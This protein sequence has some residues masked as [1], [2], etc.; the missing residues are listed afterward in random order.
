MNYGTGVPEDL[1]L[2]NVL[3]N[4]LTQLHGDPSAPA[5]GGMVAPGGALP[6]M[7]DGLGGMAGLLGMQA[8]LGGAGM[9]AGLA[10]GMAPGMAGLQM[11]MPPMQAAPEKAAA[12]KQGGG[13]DDDSDPQS[14]DG[15]ASSGEQKSRKK[16]EIGGN[17]DDLTAAEK[18]HLALQEK[19]RRAQR[20]F[21]E[22]QKAKIQ[23]L[24]QQIEELTHKV[25]SLQTENAALHSRTSILEKVLDMRNEQI[26]VMQESKEITQQVDEQ[27]EG[28]PLT[29]TAVS[30]QSISLTT[31]MLKALSPE[32]IY[33]I[34]QTYIKELSSRLVELNQ[35]GCASDDITAQVEKLTKEVSFL[36]MRLSVVRPIETRKFI[37]VS[38]QYLHNEEEA[39]DMWKSVVNSIN[40]N[41]KQ[42]LD[43]VRWKQL[44]MQ[45]VEPIVDERKKLNVQ[46]QAHLPQESF[47]TRNAI[48]YIKTHEAVAKLRENLR[49]E[50][51]VTI[52]FCA[53]VFKGVLN[54]FQMAS[55]LVQAYP[56][57][58]DALAVASAVIADMND[59]GQALPSALA[60]MQSNQGLPGLSMAAP[61]LCPASDHNPNAPSTAAA[62]AAAAAAAGVQQGALIGLGTVGQNQTLPLLQ[63]LHGVAAAPNMAAAAV[64]SLLAG[65][66]QH[67][68]A[69]RRA[70]PSGRRVAAADSKEGAKSVDDVLAAANALLDNLT[71]G[72]TPPSLLQA[73]IDE[74]EGLGY[75]C[76]E[77]GCVLVLP[78]DSDASAGPPPVSRLLQGPNWSIGMLAEPDSDDE[79]GGSPYTAQVSGPCWSVPLKPG[80]LCDFVGMLSQL[81]LMVANLAA[82]GQWHGATADRPASRVKWETSHIVMK[83]AHAPGEPGFSIEMTFRTDRRS[84]STEWPADV[85]AAA[86]A[87]VDAETGGLPGSRLRNTATVSA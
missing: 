50:H 5:S 25:G 15:S 69:P 39:I 38:R 66:L 47:H 23:D 6:M 72:Q 12:S 11:A 46:I 14:S 44:F 53:A 77:S 28:P 3:D 81:R 7:P 33:K 61:L 32:Q 84:V 78:D 62:A 64:D 79:D 45:K 18:R 63:T 31:D 42:K 55:L 8:G 40:L 76:D 4:Y 43:I 34:Y 67:C 56:A 75:V 70:G 13:G 22:R 57:V 83:A 87:A 71:S 65:Q 68:A 59:K 80:E 29:L 58:P 26:Q 35:E 82:Q 24:H 1:D 51:N 37:A 60:D 48:T 30:G 10:P 19:N 2:D 9:Y 21:R 85:A 27:T 17:D 36:L 49:A 73:S 16:R 52:E 74:L 86:I 20:R 41:D 54:S